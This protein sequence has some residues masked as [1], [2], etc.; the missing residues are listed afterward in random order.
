[1]FILTHQETREAGMSSGGRPTC[2]VHDTANS[3]C[4]TQPGACWGLCFQT[5]GSQFA[6]GHLRKETETKTESFSLVKRR[7]ILCFYLGLGTLI[8]L[9]HMETFLAFNILKSIANKRMSTAS[10]PVPPALPWR[11]VWT[12]QT[13]G[14]QYAVLE[15]EVSK[16]PSLPNSI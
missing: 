13:G 6:T 4:P 3:S 2:T 7:K 5:G 16:G 14:F 8:T 15:L 11:L 12:S 9:I 10:C 1:M